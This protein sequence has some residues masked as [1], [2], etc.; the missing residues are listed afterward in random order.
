MI[1]IILAIIGGIVLLMLFLGGIAC[2][3]LRGE[4]DKTPISYRH[5]KPDKYL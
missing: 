3:L 1:T 4:K 5:G 2:W